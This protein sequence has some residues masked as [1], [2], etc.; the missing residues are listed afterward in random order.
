[1]FKATAAPQ[2]P[3]EEQKYVRVKAVDGEDG[4]GEKFERY[5]VDFFQV[6]KTLSETKSHLVYYERAGL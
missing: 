2:R 5:P 4:G 6:L 3:P 1:M